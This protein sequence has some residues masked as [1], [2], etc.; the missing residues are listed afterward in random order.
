MGVVHSAWDTWRG[1]RVAL[2]E[3]NANGGADEDD[4]IFSEGTSSASRSLR[5]ERDLLEDLSHP[6]IVRLEGSF[7]SSGSLVLVLESLLGGDLSAYILS[8]GPLLESQ[9]Q[10]LSAQT[11]HAAA[12][13][14]ALDIVHRDLKAENFVFSTPEHKLLKLIDFGEATVQGG[15]PLTDLVGTRGY[16][17]PEV[18]SGCAYSHKCDLW[19]LGVIAFFLLTRRE[20]VDLYHPALLARSPPAVDFVRDFLNVIPEE[21]MEAEDALVH[22]WFVKPAPGPT[23]LSSGPTLLGSGRGHSQSLWP[24]SPSML[25]GG[26]L[27]ACQMSTS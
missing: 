2:K 25:K 13:L 5:T 9:A 22:A 21:R 4:L 23:L 10:A 16:M 14:H 1:K 20:D 19:S 11:L 6:H 18:A 15:T 12:Y 8:Q 27:K 26:F 17:A 7:L 24:Q 3:A